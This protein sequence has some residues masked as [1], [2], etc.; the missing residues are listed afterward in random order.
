MYS[1]CK[2]ISLNEVWTLLVRISSSNQSFKPI[3]TVK[4]DPTRMKSTRKEIKCTCQRESFALGSQCN[5]YSIGLL[6]YGGIANCMF[7]V[8]GNANFSVF[9]YQHVGIPNTK[10]ALGVQ[11]NIRTQS[12]W[13]C[14]TV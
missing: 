4:R 10:L 5:L 14:F 9:R 13:F 11:A 12:E 3:S 6:C 7:C 2:S 8:G 1:D